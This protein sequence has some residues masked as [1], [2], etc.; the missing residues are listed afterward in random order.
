MLPAPGHRTKL[1]GM[2]GPQIGGA[3]RQGRAGAESVS[4]RRGRGW[5]RGPV[6]RRGQGGLTTHRDAGAPHRLEA[7]TRPEA[8]RAAATRGWRRGLGARNRLGVWW[9]LAPDRVTRGGRGTRRDPV[10]ELQP[11]RH[12]PAGPDRTRAQPAAGTL[13]LHARN[14]YPEEVPFSGR[15]LKR[16]D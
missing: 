10:S 5:R 16:P 12:P 2:A 7:E 4:S 9:P 6:W 15:G 11:G 8:R 3:G 14:Q 13:A 1:E